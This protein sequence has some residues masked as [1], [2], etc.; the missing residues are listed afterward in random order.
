MNELFGVDKDADVRDA[1]AAGVEEDQITEEG[2]VKV[3]ADCRL[4]LLARGAW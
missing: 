3:D 1:A 4:S 2:I